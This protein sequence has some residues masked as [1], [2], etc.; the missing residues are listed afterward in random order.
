MSGVYRRPWFAPERRRRGSL[1]G[2]PGAP[3]NTVAPAVTGTTVVGSLL[4]TTNGT[5]VNTPSSFAYQWQRDDHGGGSYANIASATA[6][7]Y[8]LV[9]ADDSCQIRCVVTAANTVGSTAANSNAVGPVTEPAPVSTVAPV[10]SGT[11]TV[12]QTLS[13]TDGSWSNMGGYQPTFTYQWQRDGHGDSVYANIGGATTSSYALVD[14]DDACKV[15][16]VVTAHNSGGTASANS[17]ARGPVAEPA[18]ANTAAPTATGTR[19]VGNVLSCD[20]GTWTGMGGYN[21][22]FAYQWQTS[23]NGATGWA[24]LG[25]ATS[26]TY[27][28]QAGDLG[29]YLRCVVT[30]TNDAGSASANSNSLGP[31]VTVLPIDAQGTMLLGPQPRPPVTY[32]LLRAGREPIRLTPVANSLRFSTLAV[33]GFGACSFRLPGD[34]ARWYR[35]IPHLSKLVVTYGPRIIYEGQVEDLNRHVSSG[36]SSTQ[37]TC[38][39]YRRLLEE[40]SLLRLWSK[41]DFTFTDQWAQA[42]HPQAWAFS[43]GRFDPANLSRVG[44]M[45]KGANQVVIG[46]SEKRYA[47]WYAPTGLHVYGVAAKVNLAG[48]SNVKGSSSPR[49]LTAAPTARSRTRPTRRGRRSSRSRHRRRRSGSLSARRSAPPTSRPRTTSSASTTSASSAQP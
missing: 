28:V 5:W 43:S 18:P 22:A 15:R 30:A 31:V 1:L 47:V 45:Y 32:L 12:G 38:Y 23:A 42:D 36:E 29:N 33:G 16:C 26:A 48:S 34:L 2:G 8:T 37:V 11:A 24:N 7:T 17:N 20:T 49:S 39:G 41:R 19:V 13:T 21:P 4:S 25:G 27:T 46:T 14:A 3:R 40:T 6:A 35:D 44:V 9:D 10:A